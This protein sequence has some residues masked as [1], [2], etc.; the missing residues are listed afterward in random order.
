MSFENEI[1]SF[2]NSFSVEQLIAGIIS[3]V[4]IIIFLLELRK[5]L[6][7]QSYPDMME[8]SGIGVLATS[9][10]AITNDLLL[11]GLA[12]MLGLMIIGT[13][14]V[15]ENP[16]WVRMM[17]TFTISYG[18]FFLMVAIGFFTSVTFSSLGAAIKDFLVTL[19]I[20]ETVEIQQFFI[21]IGYNLIIWVMVFTAFLVFGRKF[22][23]VTRFI[24]PQM[25]YLVLYLVALLVLLQLNLPE[26][27]KYPAIF[28]ANIFIYM[29]SAPLLSFLYQI[30]PLKNKRVE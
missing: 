17:G 16:I 19:G 21:G 5:Y 25:T 24:S 22:I 28:V 4:L 14:E 15:R 12:G 20:S 18:F 11:S 8:L 2:L 26:I 7:Y 9:L 23:V 10:F 27:L 13:Y 29:I 1:L 6:K 3:I 30:K